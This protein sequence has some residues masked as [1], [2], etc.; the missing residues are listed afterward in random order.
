MKVNYKQPFTL[1]W[2][3]RLRNQV[4]RYTINKNYDSGDIDNY[5]ELVI[6]VYAISNKA[7]HMLVSRK[8]MKHS[9][10]VPR[11]DLSFCFNISAPELGGIEFWTP[12]QNQ[13]PI[14]YR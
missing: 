2:H 14:D 12:I 10:F 6:K 3:T 8:M 7:G 13:L 1:A 4:D 9:S 11:K 5:L